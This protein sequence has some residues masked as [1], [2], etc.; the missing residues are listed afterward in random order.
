RILQ[1]MMQELSSNIKNLDVVHTSDAGHYVLLKEKKLLMQ[2]T[3]AGIEA[4][5]AGFKDRGGYHFG[6][7]ATLNVIAYNTKAVP[8]AEAPRTWKDL[9]DPKWRG[10]LVTAHP[11][12]SGVIAT[13]VLALVGLFQ[14]PPPEQADAG[15]VGGGSVG[16]GRLG[17]AAGGG[18]RGRLHVLPGQEEGQ[19]GRDRVSE[20]GRAARGLPERD[21]QLRPPSERGQA[22]HRLHLQ[23]RRAAG[24]G[25]HRGALLRPS[26]GEVYL[27][28]APPVGPQAPAGRR[29]GAREAERGD[30]DALRR[31]LRS[32]AHRSWPTRRV[33]AVPGAGTASTRL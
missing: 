8:A 33:S 18:G 13:H 14:G 23:P 2:Y 21:H 17:G 9:L 15:A 11:R 19:P 27:R 4:F 6:L 26:A 25:R 20:G 3:P 24:A 10:K 5:G 31:V 16:G 22:L 1:R 30:Q 28:Q 12:Y 32:L 7:R 29:G